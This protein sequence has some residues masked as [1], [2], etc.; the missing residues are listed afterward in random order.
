MGWDEKG[1]DGK[2]WD[3]MGWDRSE[4]SIQSLLHEKCKVLCY[5]YALSKHITYV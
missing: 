5:K 1:W 3:G 4:Q 2:G